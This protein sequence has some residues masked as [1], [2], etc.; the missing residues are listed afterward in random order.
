MERYHGKSARNRPLLVVRRADF[1]VDTPTSATAPWK[2][3]A[4]GG[5]TSDRLGIEAARYIRLRLLGVLRCCRAHLD[6]QK[7]ICG[8]DTA[9]IVFNEHTDE[10]GAV[11][12]RLRA[13]CR[14]GSVHPTG[15]G[16]LAMIKNPDSPA[17]R[18]ARAGLW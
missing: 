5:C 17:M 18:R 8:T 6:P 1:S 10:D 2:R 15:Q 9:G 4:G 7:L 3:L 16:R 14:S 13:S 12:F 11:V